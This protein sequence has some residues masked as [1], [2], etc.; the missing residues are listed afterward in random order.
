MV[1]PI[2]LI[3]AGCVAPA[4]LLT[5][6]LENGAE[7]VLYAPRNVWLED[8]EIDLKEGKVRV[9]EFRSARINPEVVR[10]LTHRK[11]RN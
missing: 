8:V 1:I 5:V 9:G 10:I 2:L 4:P 6:P 11:R 7:M 3:C